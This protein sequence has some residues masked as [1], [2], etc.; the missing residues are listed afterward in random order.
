MPLTLHHMGLSQSERIIWLAEELGIDYQLVL[1]KRDPVF[2]PQSIKDLHPAGTAPVMEDD[3]SPVTNSRVVL[4]ESG[5]ITDYLI[6]VYGNGRL[7]R[8]PK[9]GT[10]YPSYLDWYHFANGSLQPALFRVLMTRGPSTDPNSPIVK[11]TLDKWHHHLSMLES[12]LAETGAYLAGKELTAADVMITFTLTTMR[13]FC[14]VDF[15]TEKN[16]HL[17]AYLKRIG[18]RPAYQKA[19]RICEGDDFVPL[20]GAK[21]EQFSLMKR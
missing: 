6:A 2:S 8:T 15:D 3:P 12:R 18:E 13:G 17:L 14:P 7:A 5:A 11:R 21:S 1:H 16:K 4:A 19:M 9:D 10:D 20:I